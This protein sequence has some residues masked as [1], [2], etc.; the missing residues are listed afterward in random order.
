MIVSDAKAARDFFNFMMNIA[1]VLSGSQRSW[2]ISFVTSFAALLR[3]NSVHV[4][5]LDFVRFTK[6]PTAVV[7]HFEKA[8]EPLYNKQ[9]DF[10]SGPVLLRPFHLCARWHLDCAEIGEMKQAADVYNAL[11]LLC[12]TKPDDALCILEQLP[13]QVALPFYYMLAQFGFE[14]EFHKAVKKSFQEGERKLAI[15]VLEKCS[16]TTPILLKP[17]FSDISRMGLEQTVD[18]A[19]QLIKSDFLDFGRLWN[20][21]KKC[22][23]DTIK[24]L[25]R[26]GIVQIQRRSKSVQN[27]KFILS[28]L[29]HFFSTVRGD[30]NWA[31]VA[32]AFS[33]DRHVVQ[34][35]L[36]NDQTEAASNTNVLLKWRDDFMVFIGKSPAELHRLLVVP[37]LL[38]TTGESNLS[39]EKIKWAVASL[40]VFQTEC[41]R[42]I[43]GFTLYELSKHVLSQSSIAA[44]DGFGFPSVTYTS[45]FAHAAVALRV[46]QTSSL[47][48]LIVALKSNSQLIRRAALLGL[49]FLRIDLFPFAQ[50]FDRDPLVDYVVNL[51]GDSTKV[52]PR[53]EF[54]DS[55]KGILRIL[56]EAH[57]LN[58]QDLFERTFSSYNGLKFHFLKLSVACF[59]LLP[60]RKV[61]KSSVDRI[62]SLIRSPSLL[63]KNFGIAALARIPGA[64]E[65]DWHSLI[66]FK[67]L[68]YSLCTLAVKQNKMP[69][70][71]ELL[72]VAEDFELIEVVK[73]LLSFV[74]TEKVCDFLRRT[75]PATE[76]SL[77]F[78]S[79]DIFTNAGHIAIV[80]NSIQQRPIIKELQNNEFQ[81][82]RT[83]IMKFTSDEFEALVITRFDDFALVCSIEGGMSV[84]N[85]CWNLL[86]S[87]GTVSIPCLFLAATKM[88]QRI[89]AFVEAL[90]AIPQHA[91]PDQLAKCL[92]TVGVFM[93]VG[94][95]EEP[96]E[97]IRIHYEAN[98]TDIDAEIVLALLPGLFAASPVV[99]A[100]HVDV[101]ENAP[102]SEFGDVR[103]EIVACLRL[104]KLK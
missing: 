70:V 49:N 20:H 53:L 34:T 82:L 96:F 98:V 64:P 15:S 8:T 48:K 43:E 31:S 30:I 22:K 79:I 84:S 50:E 17:H 14:D 86:G 3:G 7:N 54:A 90:L 93:L 29:R 103:D 102:I 25:V 27:S 1:V 101:L 28:V 57:S 42:I 76:L 99:R 65:F 71:C 19:G 40:P 39:H 95:T 33:R 21:L 81:K 88:R 23:F 100:V 2:V 38:L 59:L 60:S 78:N 51:L 32:E 4:A 35:I 37:Y 83:A 92:V 55:E 12:R 24:P 58:D 41:E 77:L 74:D 52:L 11:L 6:K 61:G 5:V 62:V 18:L 68:H 46:G 69:L 85:L 13:L 63:Q 56:H 104:K 26:E 87:R 16:R 47:E 75:A 67:E 89:P 9:L 36:L 44:L 91:N 66:E 73:S 80:F 94:S 10:L 97:S 45:L 72:D